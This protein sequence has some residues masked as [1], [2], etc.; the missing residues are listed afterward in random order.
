[1]TIPVREPRDIIGTIIAADARRNLRSLAHGRIEKRSIRTTTGIGARLDA[2][3][4]PAPVQRTPPPCVASSFLIGVI[5]SK[6]RD[7]VAA[8]IQHLARS[9]RPV[10]DDLR[11]TE[12]VAAACRSSKH[13]RAATDSP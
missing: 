6:F 10:F 4:A 5:L 8:T 11:T 12:R 1:M 7:T 3:S 9:I 13:R 2:P